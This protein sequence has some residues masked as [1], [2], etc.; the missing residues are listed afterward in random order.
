VIRLP[1]GASGAE[2]LCALGVV[3]RGC[4]GSNVVKQVAA[5]AGNRRTRTAGI[6]VI[7]LSVHDT[8]SGP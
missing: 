3:R 1:L 2:R 4:L 7:A 5:L 8:G 6:A